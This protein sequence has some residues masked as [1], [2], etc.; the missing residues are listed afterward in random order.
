[1]NTPATLRATDTNR[2]PLSGEPGAHPLGTGLGAALGGAAAGAAT[3]TVAGPIGTIVGAALGA[4]VGG[5]AGKSVAETL[6]PSLE[7]AY[8]RVNFADRPYV[9]AGSTYDDYGP[10]YGYGVASYGR[11]QGRSFDE[12]EANLARDWSSARGASNLDWALA[13]NAARDAW[14][15][16]GQ[17]AKG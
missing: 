14:T 2:D 6:D 17:P 8:W 12:L 3:G 15:R 9:A 10:A 4:I 13:R 5:L 11:Y 1:M 7:D 16:A